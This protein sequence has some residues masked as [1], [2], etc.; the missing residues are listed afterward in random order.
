MVLYG[1]V[2]SEFASIAS[3]TLEYATIGCIW[4]WPWVGLLVCVLRPLGAVLC[5]PRLHTTLPRVHAPTFNTHA[6]DPHDHL[7]HPPRDGQNRVATIP[8]QDDLDNSGHGGTASS[9]AQAFGLA[10]I[11]AHKEQGLQRC[12]NSS[13][14]RCGNAWQARAL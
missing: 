8:R 4:C 2:D 7:L 14:R 10:R 6:S 9:A 12:L 3:R 5:C 11:A 13:S 1:R